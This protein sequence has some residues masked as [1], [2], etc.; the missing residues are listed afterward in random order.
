M[1]HLLC[2][3]LILSCAVHT[4]AAEHSCCAPATATVRFASFA[5][6]KRFVAKHEAP[7]PF[8]LSEPKGTMIRFA[9]DDG[10]AASGYEVRA[11]QKTNKYVFVLHEWWGLNDYIKQEAERIQQE[12]GNVTVI[13]LDLYDGNVASTR[14]DAAKYMQGAKT[15]RLQAI[16]RGAKS[17]AGKDA[18]VCT[19][20]WCFGGGW[21][22]QTTL[23]LGS[24][25][26]GCVMYYGMPEND[27]Q[28]IA[29]LSAPVLGIFAKQD[30]WITPQVVET[31][32]KAMKKAGKAITVKSY[33]AD[34]AFANP[35]NP[36]YAKEFAEEAH[37]H[38]IEFLR[39]QL[40]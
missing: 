5:K 30:K 39:T 24:N 38:A 18:R 10:K 37:K 9:T 14:E 20:G 33:D 22:L 25:A 6:Q 28:K 3:A 8:T 40:Q 36:H 4:V 31:F 32:E 23:L 15:E 21:S 13:A 7:L 35:S 1:K 27:A 11:A 16:I 29:S 12:L 34:H 19:V 26:A 2:L 17:Y